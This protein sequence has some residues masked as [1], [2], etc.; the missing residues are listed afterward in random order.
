M[1]KAVFIQCL[2]L[3]VFGLNSVASGQHNEEDSEFRGFFKKHINIEKLESS[4]VLTYSKSDSII[5]R[6]NQDQLDKRL[7]DE[8]FTY[9]G[10]NNKKLLEIIGKEFSFPAKKIA[11]PNQFNFPTFF[12]FLQI[13]KVINKTLYLKLDVYKILLLV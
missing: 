10:M 12:H 5:E 11:N 1:S 4:P 13:S 6:I 2:L 8:R 9:Q 7:A 3:V